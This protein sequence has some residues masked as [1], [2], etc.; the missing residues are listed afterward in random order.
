MKGFVS[1]LDFEEYSQGRTK[2]LIVWRARVYVLPGLLSVPV[3]IE[4]EREPAE[5]QAEVEG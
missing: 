3:T 5:V 2:R 4:V 1:K